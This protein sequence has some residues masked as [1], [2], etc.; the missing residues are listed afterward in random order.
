MLERVDFINKIHLNFY[1]ED[2]N[3]QIIDNDP[4]IFIKHVNDD[5]LKDSVVGLL[6]IFKSVIPFNYAD[7]FKYQDLLPIID[8]KEHYK[9]GTIICCAYNKIYDSLVN[10]NI[11]SSEK[12][13]LYRIEGDSGK[14][15][16]QDLISKKTPISDKFDYTSMTPSPMEDGVLKSIFGSRE[17]NTE[18]Y[19]KEWSFAFKNKEDIEKWFN[20]DEGLLEYIIDYGGANVVEYE[21]DSSHVMTTE[22][23]AIFRKNKSNKII[24]YKLISEMDKIRIDIK[25][26]TSKPKEFKKQLGFD[27]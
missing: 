5:L 27:F 3:K 16:Y 11:V 26:Y 4:I 24:D 25:E 9:H 8:I 10:K 13:K 17:Y 1:N 2:I 7:N 15:I 21:I 14:G 12:I 18:L 23:Q 19:Q 20:S 6:D 22:H